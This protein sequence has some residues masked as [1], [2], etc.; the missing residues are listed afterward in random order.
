[1][2]RRKEHDASP[3]VATFRNPEHPAFSFQK[4]FEAM[5]RRGLIILAGRPAL[6]N[7]FRIGCMGV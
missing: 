1:M 3:I 4:L 5:Q 7:T 2:Q 6:A